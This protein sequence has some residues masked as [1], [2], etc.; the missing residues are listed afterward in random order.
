MAIGISYNDFWDMTPKII[1]LH[2]EAYN[3]R[4]E[5]KFDYD[6]YIAYLQGVYFA[7]SLNCTVGNMFKGKGQKPYEYPSK[8]YDFKEKTYT[9]EELDQQ[10]KAFFESLLV[11]QTNFELSKGSSE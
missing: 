6:N 5:L 3:K 1:M 4:E 9:E 8:P 7:E 10:R 11:A 2:I